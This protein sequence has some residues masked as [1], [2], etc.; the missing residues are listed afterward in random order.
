MDAV[1]ILQHSYKLN[2]CEET[3]T[4]GIYSS[5]E[6]AEKVVLKYKS[7]SGFKDH[8]D[9]FYIDEYKIDKNHWEEGFIAVD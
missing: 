2:E 8:P 3:K 5:R 9:C 7:L 1:F 6:I 4:I